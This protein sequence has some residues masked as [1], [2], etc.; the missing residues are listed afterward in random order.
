MRQVQK[1][2]A[3]TLDNDPRGEREFGA[4]DFDWGGYGER[5]FWKID[6]YDKELRFGSP[7]PSDPAKTT[8][9]LSIMLASE[10]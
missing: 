5:I 4:I 6:Y 1:F 10:W 2:D 7:D 8:R 3:F 9:I